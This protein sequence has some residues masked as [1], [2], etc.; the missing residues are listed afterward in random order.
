MELFYLVSMIHNDIHTK[1]RSSSRQQAVGLRS[2][3][4][5]TYVSMYMLKM[6]KQA[7][8]NEILAGFSSMS[9]TGSSRHG[10]VTGQKTRCLPWHAYPDV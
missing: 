4:L 8:S 7:P 10:H 6:Y 3:L 5:W 9:K 1:D 2:N